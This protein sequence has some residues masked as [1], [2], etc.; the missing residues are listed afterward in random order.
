MAEAIAAVGLLASIASLIDVTSRSLSRLQECR[1][2]DIQLPA[3]YQ[4]VADQ[5]PLVLE[6]MQTL[7]GRL[8]DRPLDH[9]TNNAL[10]SA[11]QGCN[12]QISKIQKLIEKR[13][14]AG[15]ES[16]LKRIRK[17]F[18]SVY[19]E[20]TLVESLRVLET[21]KTTIHIYMTNSTHD[22]HLEMTD[23]IYDIPSRQLSFFVGRQDVL[24]KLSDC[25][26]NTTVHSTRRKAAILTGMGGQGKTQIAL[27][28]CQR[29][30]LSKTYGI[31]VWIDA[32][33]EITLIRTF[34]NIVDKLPTPGLS[35]LDDNARVSH[36][37]TFLN[38]TPQ[39]WLLIFDNFDRP[40]LFPNITDFFP[41]SKN[42]AFIVTS[43]H[44]ESERLGTTIAVPK[45]SDVES[46]QLLIHRA[47]AEM[48]QDNTEYARD[49]AQ[50]LGHLPLALDQA[51]SYL[52]SRGLPI[53]SFLEH[54]SHR[55]TLILK[56]TPAFWEY[57]KRSGLNEDETTMNAFTT[58][59]LS[60]DQVIDD[61]ERL[62][63]THFLTLS[64]FLGQASIGMS[65][66]RDYL[67][68]IPQV[69]H[70]AL[71]FLTDRW[72]D[73][74]RY[75]DFVAALRARSLLVSVD[76]ATPENKFY[77]HPLVGEWLRLR[78]SPSERS[79][80][81]RESI[82]QLAASAS[83]QRYRLNLEGR[84]TLIAH[85][86][87]CLENAQDTLHLDSPWTSSLSQKAADAFAYVYNAHGRYKE[88]AVLYQSLYD[89]QNATGTLYA[90][91][92]AMNLANILRNQG[93]L[94]KAETLYE[95]VVA[96]RER[97]LG[98]F[99]IETLRALE[100]LADVHSLQNDF[101][102]ADSEHQQLIHG[103]KNM[104]VRSASGEVQIIE[105]LA[106]IRSHRSRSNV[107]RAL[108][109]EALV[110]RCRTLGPRH[111]DTLRCVEGLAIVY[112][113]Q[114]RIE[115][116]LHLY[117][118][119]LGALEL[120]FGKDHPD[121]L[122]TVLNMSIAYFHQPNLIVAGSMAERAYEGFKALL[123]PDHEETKRAADQL[124]NVRQYVQSGSR[125]FRLQSLWIP[126]LL[127][128]LESPGSET[129][130][131]GSGETLLQI[132][133]YLSQLSCISRS[134]DVGNHGTHPGAETSLPPSE[135]GCGGRGSHS[136]GRALGQ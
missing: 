10:S 118:E 21:Y 37:K 34:S 125:V 51:G 58:F 99:H 27:E 134:R 135:K 112:R 39:S 74:Y 124:A 76:F 11:V 80:Y 53:S 131:S 36:V 98:P 64:A 133:H 108:Y 68:S 72:W 105:G 28:Y 46:I 85:I 55:R 113:Q 6:V 13:A 66:F 32:S 110:E 104:T 95:S 123:G 114:S 97:Q 42:G 26:E 92:I 40:D 69:P 117:N 88:A 4:D 30:Q 107:A 121:T 7:Q 115:E 136:A 78:I 50:K 116:S 120:E 45:M 101:T 96:H 90:L 77:L 57:R 56:H 61:D 49:I 24:E 60:L 119:V 106:N 93:Q 79:D 89:R 41:T 18:G 23:A 17:A 109:G 2:A 33:T 20:K 62:A 86:D 15:N 52:S 5:L 81:V 8:R 22:T 25:L 54:F 70:W 47:N 31:I 87:A 126:R 48:T 111:P 44:N 71:R 1:S 100:G 130:P 43:R 102:R 29:A 129:V 103:H 63:I 132:D 35:F 75:Q 84:R 67:L 38:Q 122:R 82:Q 12:R 73:F 59:E 9:D 14:L 83:G 128:S 65:L 127:E 94:E 19:D 16:N 3:L 91:R